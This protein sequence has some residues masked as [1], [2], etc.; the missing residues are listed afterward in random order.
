M[1]PYGNNYFFLTK[2]QM[3]SHDSIVL[4]D[5]ITHVGGKRSISYVKNWQNHTLVTATQNLQSS[6][7]LTSNILLKQ[8]TASIN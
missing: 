6:I 1:I 2:F 4:V 5:I 8:A 3:R 7:T